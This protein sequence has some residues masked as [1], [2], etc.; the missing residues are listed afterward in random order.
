MTRWSWLLVLVASIAHAQ[1]PDVPPNETPLERDQRYELRARLDPATHEVHGEGR[2]TWR[3]ESRVPVGELVFHRYLE[4]FRH[5]RTVFMRES[6]QQLR[7][8]RFRGGGGLD[9]NALELETPTGRVDLLTG[10]DDDPEADDRTQLRVRLPRELSPGES[11][12]LHVRFVAKLPPVFARSGYHGDF[13][14]VAQWF[15]KLARLENDGTWASFPYHGFGEFYADFATYDLTVEV[16]RGWDAVATGVERSR[17]EADGHVRLRFEQDRVHDAV[18]VAAPWFER[19]EAEHREGDRSVRVLLVHPPGFGSAA[20]RHLEVTLTS[21][22][23]FGRVYGAYPYDQL[24]VVVPPR[25]A[26]GAAGMEYPTLFLTAGPW[27]HVPGLPIA[28]QDEVTAHELAHQWFQGMVATHEVRW[29]MLDEGLTEWATGDALEA[30]HGR[31]R[32]GIDVF[33][34][35]LDGFELRRALALRGT[36]TPAPGSSVTDFRR[37]N[38]YGRAIYGRTAVVM[39][40]VARTWGRARLHRTLGHYARS[41]RFRHPT[42]DALFASFDREYGPWMARDVL[43]PALMIGAHSSVHVGRPELRD[44]RTRIRLEQ[45]GVALPR[46]VL[47]RGPSGER[48]VTWPAR[49]AALDLDEEGEWTSVWADPHAHALLDP[50]RRDDARSTQ[51]TEIP[52]GLFTR[53][54]VWLQALLQGVGP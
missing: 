15:P 13:H 16:P 19:L 1:A 50:D 12:T 44:G 53:A 46:R 21:L 6:G 29:P 25:G 49:A 28:L 10:T 27:L 38:D 11:I 35:S 26:D 31:A 43:R 3:N 42:P 24:T 41:Q 17:E 32:S 14:V 4:A 54:L 18:F 48:H 22:A 20:R 39:E 5:E 8:V 33:G 45:R 36:P 40:T 51:P 23:H 52:E 30:M 34:L 37:S 9:V 47:L 7:G 2:I